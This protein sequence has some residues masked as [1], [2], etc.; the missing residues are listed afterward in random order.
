M[1]SCESLQPSLT[2]GKDSF[3][4][5]IFLYYFN[6]AAKT[7]ALVQ[8][9][10]YA[11]VFGRGLVTD[12]EDWSKNPRFEEEPPNSVGEAFLRIVCGGR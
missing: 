1:D 6:C 5:S 10:Y 12:A 2:P 8:I 7:A 11:E 3:L 4:S 9:N